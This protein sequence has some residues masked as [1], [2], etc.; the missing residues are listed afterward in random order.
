MFVFLF[1][2]LCVDVYHNMYVLYMYNIH[3]IRMSMTLLPG[4]IMDMNSGGNLPAAKLA[5]GFSSDAGC[6]GT[7]HAGNCA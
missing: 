1:S 2:V 3:V 4:T 5:A 7:S 6:F